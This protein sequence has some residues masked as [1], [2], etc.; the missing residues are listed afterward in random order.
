M[1]SC[2]QGQQRG[3]H[4]L[5]S[6]GSPEGWS[7]SGAPENVPR[8]QVAHL[9]MSTPQRWKPQFLHTLCSN[10]CGLPFFFLLLFFFFLSFFF[11]LPSGD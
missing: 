1:S 5:D 2:S 3:V 7:L 10:I 6:K 11:I 9:Q 4:V 8:L